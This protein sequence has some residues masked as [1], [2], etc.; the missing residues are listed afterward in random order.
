DNINQKDSATG[1]VNGHR[2]EIAVLKSS[3]PSHVCSGK[4]ASVAFSYTVTNIGDFFS[5]SGTL[6]D[7]NG[8]PGSTG[9]DFTAAWGPLAPGANQTLSQSR[10]LNL[11]SP[12]VN[13]ARATGTTGPGGAASVSA[14]DTTIV[15]RSEERRVGKE[16]GAP[17]QVCECKYAKETYNYIV[18]NLGDF[19]AASGNL[20]DDN[21]TPGNAGDDFSFAWGPLAPEQTKTVTVPRT[22]NLTGALINTA[23]ATGTTGPG[24]TASVS[25]QDTTIVV[26]HRC[27]IAFL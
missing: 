11:T 25:A 14:Q 23:R 12:L 19:F 5:A 7:D 22:V 16:C 6:V 24:G 26:P 10:T 17:C 21:G 18:G 4:D 27:V 20:V 15:V 9:D 3:S 13:T 1:T 2:C 8:T